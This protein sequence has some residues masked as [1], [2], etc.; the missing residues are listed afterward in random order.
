MNAISSSNMG[1]ID[2][3]RIYDVIANSTKIQ[4]I[5]T[6]FVFPTKSLHQIFS[7][8][9]F[10]PS[11]ST[12]NFPL[13]MFTKSPTQNLPPKSFKQKLRK[14]KVT[15]SHSLFS[16]WP[17]NI[18]LKITF[19]KYA[20]SVCAATSLIAWGS[21]AK[22]RHMEVFFRWQMHPIRLNRGGRKNSQSLEDA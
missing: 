13:K 16:F 5:F 18:F 11:F 7:T 10:S 8:D 21:C 2:C 9:K 14:S 22:N 6:F 3:S 1:W 4:P 15:N 17:G 19:G 12:T 20:I